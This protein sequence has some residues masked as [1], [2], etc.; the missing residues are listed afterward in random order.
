MLF[1][2][3]IL[4]SV[5]KSC[6]F[7]VMYFKCNKIDSWRLRFY[8]LDFIYFFLS[9]WYFGH[10]RFGPQDSLKAFDPFILFPS[11]FEHKMSQAHLVLFFPPPALK[12]AMSPRTYLVI[13]LGALFYCGLKSFENVCVR[14]TL[15]DPAV[16]TLAYS[17]WLSLWWT[18]SPSR[19]IV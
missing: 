14:M 4:S 3:P 7:W 1:S 10:L 16:Q 2:V 6:L 13:L 5:R 19:F 18:L 9:L 12:L 15:D 8:S 11:L 17:Q